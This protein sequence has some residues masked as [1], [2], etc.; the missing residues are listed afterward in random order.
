[1]LI[2]AES[3]AGL[4]HALADRRHLLGTFLQVNDPTLV[5]V[6]GQ[7]GF[8][9]ALIDLEHGGLTQASIGPLVRAADA[10]DLPLLVRLGADDLSGVGQI[11]DTGCRGILAA[12]VLSAEDARNVIKAAHYEPL[13]GRGACPGV[14]A[15]GY[16]WSSWPDHVRLASESTIVGVAVES[17]AGIASLDS[18]LAVPGLDFVFL[19]VFDLAKSLGHPGEV[20][21]PD[22]V[23]ALRSLVERAATYGIPVGT[24]APDVDV[25]R[26]WLGLGVTLMTVATDVLMWRSACVKTVSEWRRDVLVANAPNQTGVVG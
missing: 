17:G 23:G 7:A 1:M 4:K 26:R 20:T 21:H 22:V 13:G 8:D 2:D 19:G 3:R 12:R 16:G 11:L 24:W 18:I 14:R 15:S 10:V 5:E 6:L 25:A 9:F